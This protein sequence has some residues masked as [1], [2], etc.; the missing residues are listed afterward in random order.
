MH[1]G[2]GGLIVLAVIITWAIQFWP[3]V[4]FAAA[5]IGLIFYLNLRKKRAQAAKDL[6]DISEYESITKLHQYKSLLDQGA[7]TQAEYDAKKEELLRI[8]TDGNNNDK[9]ADDD[10]QDF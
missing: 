9:S 10:W 2:C 5:V 8:S 1:L 4:L 3:I 7:I 6:E